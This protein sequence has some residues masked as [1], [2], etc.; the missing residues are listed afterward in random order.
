M[1]QSPAISLSGMQF[2]WQ[3]RTGFAL[4]VDTF[5]MVRG[6]RLLLVA[7]SGTGKSTLIGLIAGITRPQKGSVCVLGTDL[8][9]LSQWRRDRFRAEHIGLIFQSLNLV[10][11]L[12]ALENILLPLSFAPA[13]LKRAGGVEGARTQ[14]LQMLD[15][16][17]LPSAEVA[18]L[19][20]SQLSLGQQQRVAAL[21]A[22][23]GAPDLI[24]AD[25]P[26]SALD[27]DR[28][29]AF[30]QMLQAQLEGTGSSLLMVSHDPSLLG[31]D[32]VIALADFARAGR[33]LA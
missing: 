6:E 26:T 30:L 31:F 25:E 16:I 13:R 22:L 8:T 21:R 33:A 9:R 28:Q 11:Y 14:A 1:A 3:G 2:A 32:R 15:A 7:P 18:G 27:R 29:A 19:R 20:A 17:G 12:T 24:V 5:T 23:I 10:S 4:A